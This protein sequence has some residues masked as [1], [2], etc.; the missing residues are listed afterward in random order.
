MEVRVENRADELR[1][2]R[3]CVND[4]VSVMALP[5]LWAGGEPREIVKTLLEALVGMLRLDFVYARV[6][7]LVGVPFES[8][9]FAGQVRPEVTPEEIG[10]A[11]EGTLVCAT[12]ARAVV[13]N[14]A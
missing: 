5:A 7:E 13:P 12:P 3:N 14:P 6:D 2:L 8:V 10:R 9:R 11:F 4:L 1:R